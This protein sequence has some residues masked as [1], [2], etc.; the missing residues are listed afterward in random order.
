MTRT[1]H[2][3]LRRGQLRNWHWCAWSI[4]TA[5]VPSSSCS[6]AWY[7]RCCAQ[8][9]HGDT[10]ERPTLMFRSTLKSPA[11]QYKPPVWN[12]RC[13]MPSLSRTPSASGDGTSVRVA[14]RPRNRAGTEPEGATI[15]F[16]GCEQLGAA[17]LRG[18]GCAANDTTIHQLRAKDHGPWRL[19][20][21]NVT[22]LAGFLLAKTAAAH[23]RREPKDWYDIAFV[24]LNNENGDALAAA[25]R[26]REV[27]GDPTGTIRTQLQDL[28]ANFANSST[29]GTSAYVNQITLDHPEVDPST[30]AAD[31]ILAVGMFTDRLLGI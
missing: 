6:A 19:A 25:A 10:P 18:T 2:D 17:N 31:A 29:Q 5:A 30:A 15:E 12:K 14:R 11:A 23:G 24:L 16:A 4:T 1:L 26:V 27:F 8:G 22:G 28:Q 13:A 9:R 21:I 3:R 7:P 20:G